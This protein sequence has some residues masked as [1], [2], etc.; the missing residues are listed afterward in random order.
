VEEGG[1]G[2]LALVLVGVLV[3]WQVTK[4]QAL[5]RLGLLS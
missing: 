5:Q 4:G 2:G 1:I 3:I